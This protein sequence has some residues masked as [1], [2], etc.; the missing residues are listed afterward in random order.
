M[1]ADRVDAGRRLAA[2]LAPED[3]SN[4]LVLGIPRG[5]VVVAA[6][7]ARELALPLDIIVPR[8]I[9]A[10]A[11]PEMAV[12]AVAQDGTAIFDS[13]LLRR[14]GLAER[15]LRPQ[16]ADQLREIERRMTLYSGTGTPPGYIGRTVILVDDGIATGYTVQAALRSLRRAGPR[17]IWLAVPVAP[18][19]TLK[20]LEPEVDRIVCL[21]SPVHFYAVG[22]FYADFN[23]TDDQEVIALLRPGADA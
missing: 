11:N 16:V 3:F 10:P 19:E 23:Q 15:D 1:F 4:G 9:G 7:V 17:M 8:K 2:R 12:G 20:R 14:L 5:G 18:P 21:E 13:D 6:V 22:Q